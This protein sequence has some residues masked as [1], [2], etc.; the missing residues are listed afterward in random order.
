MTPKFGAEDCSC[1]EKRLIFGELLLSLAILFTKGRNYSPA[2][3]QE[4]VKY[5]QTRTTKRDAAIKRFVAT[6]SVL[7]EEVPQP[8]P[9]ANEI[10]TKTQPRVARRYLRNV[11]G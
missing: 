9:E 7:K 1:L 8:N 3:R 4:G 10:L 11:Y 5:A 6:P 2:Y